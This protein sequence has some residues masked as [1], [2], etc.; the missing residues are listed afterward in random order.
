VT[1]HPIRTLP[2]GTRVYSNGT[3]YKPKPV[4]ER[5]YGVRRPDD[6][7]AVRYKG[8]WFLP[9]LLQPDDKRVMPLTRPDSDAYDHMDKPRK[10]R[11]DVCKRPEAL[12][13]K[14]KWRRDR[15]Q[16]RTASSSAISAS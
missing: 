3:R 4:E 6:P 12:R 9:L 16:M 8:D 10:C 15:R 13:W 7:R 5:K 11:C 2:D 14:R 1:H